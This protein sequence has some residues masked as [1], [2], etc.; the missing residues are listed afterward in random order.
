MHGDHAFFAGAVVDHIAFYH[1]AAGGVYIEILL[2]LADQ[3]AGGQVMAVYPVLSGA[4]KNAVVNAGCVVSQVGGMLRLLPGKFTGFDVQRRGH[5]PMGAEDHTL[6]GFVPNKSCRGVAALAMAV[7]P[8]NFA[9][10][11]IAS[12]NL[13]GTACHHDTVTGQHIHPGV[14]I[15]IQGQLPLPQQAAIVNIQTVQISAAI[16]KID[17]AILNVD[18]ALD[19][20]LGIEEPFYRTGLAAEPVDAHLGAVTIVAGADEQIAILQNRLA[21]LYPSRQLC[22]PDTV[23]GTGHR[24]LIV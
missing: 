22:P 3:F 8:K 9:G 18:A 13:P 19:A 1:G 11:C 23:V 10:V 15:V 20:M 4:V 24:Q 12:K 14:A 7:R 2:L 5:V 17:L 16:L 6:V 21:E